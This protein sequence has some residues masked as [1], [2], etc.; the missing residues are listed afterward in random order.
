MASRIIEIQAHVVVQ[1]ALVSLQGQGIVAA[2]F[3]DLFGDRALAI[4]RVDGD[5]RPF[6]RQHL[7]KLGTAVISFDFTSVAISCHHQ[8]LLAAPGA[9]HVQRRL[10]AGLVE[11]TAQQLAVYRDNALNCVENFAMK[12]WNTARN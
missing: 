8:A 2:L 7:H 10:A 3:H 9:D 12:R 11:R 1:T 5:D 4:E 6:Q